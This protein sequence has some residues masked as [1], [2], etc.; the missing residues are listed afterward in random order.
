[1]M[2]EERSNQVTIVDI[3]MPFFSMVIFMVKA[4]IAA[5]PAMLILSIIATVAFALMGSMF[6]TLSTHF[7]SMQM[8][9]P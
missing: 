2:S 7:S 8:Q 4:A 5:I 3:K 6:G 1:M 9:Y